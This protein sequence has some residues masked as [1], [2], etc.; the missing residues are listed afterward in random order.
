MS[1]L[2][3]MS[4]VF[5]QKVSAAVDKAEDPSQALDL[6][7]QK[8]LE[9]LQ[10]ARRSVADVLTSEKRLELQADQ[11]TQSIAKLQGQARTALGQGKED[12]AREALTR[13]QLA[14]TQL[15]GLTEQIA[16]VKQQE[17][18]LEITVQKLQARIETFRMQ[19]DT[20]KAQYQAAKASTN[21]AE[22]ATGLSEQMADVSM[23][24]DRSRDKIAQMQARSAAV[25]Q[26]LDSGVLDGPGA[27]GGD[28]IDRQLGS[29]S[30]DAA[31]QA[32]LDAMKP[33]IP[34]PPPNPALPVQRHPHLRLPHPL[35]GEAVRHSPKLTRRGQQR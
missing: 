3:R 2:R 29:G 17:Q 20:M 30:G 11:L 26:L 9:A 8:Q 18:K 28:D 7:Y 15:D 12:L 5:Q 14:Q 1:I 10:Q 24:V 6:S 23:M 21:V 35:S 32:Q 25:G 33:Q 13:A 22:T 4:D 31:V 16:T 34:L 19:R 27:S